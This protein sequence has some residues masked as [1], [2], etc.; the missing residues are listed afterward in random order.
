MSDKCRFC[1]IINKN[2]KI[3]EEIDKPIMVGEKYFSLVSIGAFV[4]G[5]T[6]IVSREH[7][8]NLCED[9]L[10]QDFFGYLQE[11][12]ARVRKKL[13]WNSRIIVFEHGANSCDS[14]TACGTS[15]AH[16]HVLP[17]EQSILEDITREKSWIKCK[18]GMVKDV[19]GEKEYLLYCEEIDK[20]MEAEVYIHI[21]AT[22]ESQYFRRVICNKLQLESSYSYKED[23]RFEESMQTYRILEE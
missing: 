9:Y 5:W 10:C 12:V 18:W 6:L 23:A 19:V 3:Y 21:V 8:Y 7:R 11:H 14:E 16:L 4:K 15:H 22:P 13:N 17:L 2:T 20:G 1:N